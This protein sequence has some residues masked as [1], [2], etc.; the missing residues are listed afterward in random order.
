MVDGISRTAPPAI[1]CRAVISSG[2]HRIGVDSSPLNRSMVRE[3]DA[4]FGSF[5]ANRSHDESAAVALAQADRGWLSRLI[6]R[7]VA[8]A[9]WQDALERRPDD[10]KVVLDFTL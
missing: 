4:V 3:N 8:L 10:V 5:N 7:R 6:S 9:Q 2:Q 1:T